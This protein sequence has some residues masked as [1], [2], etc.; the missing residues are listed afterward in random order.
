SQPPG[1]AHI[2]QIIRKS[3]IPMSSIA[4]GA[5]L[6]IQI[7]LGPVP[8]QSNRNIYIKRKFTPAVVDSGFG[9]NNISGSSKTIAPSDQIIYGNTFV[10]CTEKNTQTFSG[11]NVSHTQPGSILVWNGELHG[12]TS[13]RF[14]VHFSGIGQ[15]IKCPIQHKTIRQHS[16]SL[17]IKCQ[18]K[19]SIP[20][21]YRLING[22]I[23]GL[24]SIG[25]LIIE[26]TLCSIIPCR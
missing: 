23:K 7:T 22:Y 19:T 24:V 20:R 13:C 10:S 25:T 6:F 4:K 5:V 2:D 26:G 12:T 11:S 1:K 15:I 21:L 8:F 3:R 17:K 18:S 9:R 16:I 14:P